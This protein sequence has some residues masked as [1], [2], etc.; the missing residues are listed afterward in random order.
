MSLFFLLL[1][2]EGDDDQNEFDSLK[3][4]TGAE[5]RQM[6]VDLHEERIS[7]LK[8]AA[9]SFRQGNLTGKASAAYYSQQGQNVFVKVSRL[10]RIGAEK[11]YKERNKD[12]GDENVI[13]LD[14]HYLTVAEAQSLTA[15]FIAHHSRKRTT[16]IKIVTGR[17]NHSAGGTCKLTVAITSFLRAQDRKYSFDNIATFTIYFK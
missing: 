3:C 2:L 9:A 15:A 10:H 12:I 7:N 4:F 1:V 13:N 6:A 8:R 14:L 5:V 11:I 17:G 16:W